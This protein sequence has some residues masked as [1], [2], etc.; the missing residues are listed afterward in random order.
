[1]GWLIAWAILLLC[2]VTPPRILGIIAVIYLSIYITLAIIAW[3]G[4]K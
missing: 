4:K 3:K 2:V 1:M